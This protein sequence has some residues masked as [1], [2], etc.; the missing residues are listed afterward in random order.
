MVDLKPEGLDFN[1]LV[2]HPVA[3]CGQQLIADNSGALYWPG[4]GTLLVADL[5]LAGATDGAAPVDARQVLT[6]LADVM[7]R[8]QPARVIVLGGAPDAGAA[9]RLGSDV[10]EILR[11]QREDRDWTWVAGV[12]QNP[13]AA[14][15][16]GGRVVSELRIAGLA[17]RPHPTPGRATH[18]IAAH[19]RPMAHVSLHGYSVRRPCFVGNRLRLV[20]PAFGVPA[21]GTNVLDPAIQR[22]FG[23]DGMAVWLLGREGIY[24]VPTRLLAAD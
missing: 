21:S 3:V 20:M 10:A 8:Y 16:L 23:H 7:D 11:I 22:L 14:P 24:P 13:V 9:F 6:V 12:G 17:L 18:E 1:D 19:L 2:S 5:P 15:Q 4:Q